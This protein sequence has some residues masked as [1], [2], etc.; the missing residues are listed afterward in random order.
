M[1]TL[2]YYRGSCNQC[3][4][5]YGRKRYTENLEIIRKWRAEHSG[6]LKEYQRKYRAKYPDRVK[7]SQRKWRAEHPKQEKH[8]V[9]KWRAQHPEQCM[10]RQHEYNQTP[11][12]KLA[13]KNGV[14]NRRAREKG[15]KITL[16][17][18]TAIKQQQDFRCYWCKQRVENLT[19]DHVIPL[20]KNGLHEASNIVAACKP[21]N[22]KKN[23]SIWSLV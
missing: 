9:C 15:G 7:E 12:G 11:Q 23:A 10:K 14:H 19:M 8:R 3:C 22:C 20:S 17:E 5:E 6:E 1:K 13:V 4:K 21:C 2:G 18:W 16:A